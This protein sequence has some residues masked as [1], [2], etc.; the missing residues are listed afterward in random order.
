MA[1]KMAQNPIYTYYCD[2]V[3][4]KVRARGASC[5]PAFI[6]LVLIKGIRRRGESKIY[7]CYPRGLR[8][9]PQT[10]HK[11]DGMI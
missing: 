8:A 1:K 5:H 9:S 4:H 6:V 3:W 11:R 10:Y 2:G 7:F